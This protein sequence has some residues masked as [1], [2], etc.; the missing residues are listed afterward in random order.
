MLINVFVVIDVRKCVHG[1]IVLE[2][3]S[4]FKGVEMKHAFLI[5]AH[6]N[7]NQLNTLIHLLDNKRSDI[8]LHVDKRSPDFT[9]PNLQFSNI[10]LVPRMRTNWGG[11]SL[12]ECELMLL[13]MATENDAYDYIHLIS[14][15]DL[16]IKPLDDI[17]SFF[18]SHSCYNFIFYNNPEL[19]EYNNERVKYYYPFQ[20]I[21]GRRRSVWSISQRILVQ[22][23]RLVG[24]DRRKKYAG[25]FKSGSQWWSIHSDLA[26]YILSKSNQ[27]RRIFRYTMCDEMFVQT[28]VYN[29][30]Y[31]Q[32]VYIGEEFDQHSNARMIEFRN[33]SCHTW[34]INE[35]DKIKQ[36]DLLF[37]RKFDENID[38]EII[39]EVVKIVEN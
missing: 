32:S 20:D 22:V 5:L 6:K 18:D 28:L 10:F 24:V 7:Y 16:P 39:N 34:T 13:K 27:I 37:A 19:S 12:V 8:F 15:Q 1:N 35:F 23:Q 21:K 31:Y 9:V 38:P 30:D 4:R 17:F 11:F 2:N 26:Q 29:S 25:V 3:R 14:G 33:G 36:S